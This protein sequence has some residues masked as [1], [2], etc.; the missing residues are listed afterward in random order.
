M[1]CNKMQICTQQKD[2]YKNKLQSSIFYLI[3]LCILYS[4]EFSS[5]ETIQLPNMFITERLVH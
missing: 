5:L 3:Y 4:I 2:N 1:L